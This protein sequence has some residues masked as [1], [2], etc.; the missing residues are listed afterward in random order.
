[1]P[2]LYEEYWLKQYLLFP[3]TTMHRKVT[4]QEVSSNPQFSR[5]TVMIRTTKKQKQEKAETE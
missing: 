3:F 1:M 4:L 5:S 2:S